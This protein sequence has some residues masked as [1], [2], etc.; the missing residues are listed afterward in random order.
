MAFLENLGETYYDQFVLKFV[1]SNSIKKVEQMEKWKNVTCERCVV[2][3]EY[4]P[5]DYLC[6]TSGTSLQCPGSPALYTT[7]GWA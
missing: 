7:R 6:Q 1:E 3:M 5:W 2:M 4:L